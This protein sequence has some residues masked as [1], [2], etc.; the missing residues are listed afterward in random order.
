MNIKCVFGLLI[1]THQLIATLYNCFEYLQTWGGG[2]NNFVFQ[3]AKYK[4]GNFFLNSMLGKTEAGEISAL[5]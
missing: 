5:T 2:D 3:H 4:C 1:R